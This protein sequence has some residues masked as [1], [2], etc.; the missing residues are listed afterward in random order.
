MA[1]HFSA[2]AAAALVLFDKNNRSSFGELGIA[3]G[4]TCQNALAFQ[5]RPDSYPDIGINYELNCRYFKI[6]KRDLLRLDTD[7]VPLPTQPNATTNAATI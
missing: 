7:G 6:M 4:G 5:S 2:G 1:R 3:P